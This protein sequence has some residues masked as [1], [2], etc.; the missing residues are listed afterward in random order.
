MMKT[1]TRKIIQ[2]ALEMALR[3]HNE[4]MEDAGLPKGS[5]KIEEALKI[6]ALEPGEKEID[7]WIIND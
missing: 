4:L 1:E 6:L 3:H 5:K 7:D 2:E